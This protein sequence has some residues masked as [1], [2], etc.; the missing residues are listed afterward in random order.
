MPDPAEPLKQLW[1]EWVSEH[2]GWTTLSQ[3]QQ[4]GPQPHSPAVSPVRLSGF[5]WKKNSPR[6]VLAPWEFSCFSRSLSGGNNSKMMSGNVLQCFHSRVPER[7]DPKAS[8]FSGSIS[9]ASFQFQGGDLLRGYHRGLS[10]HTIPA[11][12][13][14]WVRFEVLR[15]VGMPD[16]VL[17][18]IPGA[19]NVLAQCRCSIKVLQKHKQSN[20]ILIAT[21]THKDHQNKNPE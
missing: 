21:Q 12:R 19:Y 15:R 17:H 7:G 1:N 18:W 2:S 14:H 16:T 10:A 8:Y 13:N 20:P 3:D 4:C 5:L 11:L 9:Q 6:S